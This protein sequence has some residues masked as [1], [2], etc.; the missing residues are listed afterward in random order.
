[1]TAPAY[2]P[3]Q[4]LTVNEAAAYLSV[5]RRQMYV[6]SAEAGAG[7]DGLPVVTVGRSRRF[8]VRDLDAFVERHMIR[9]GRAS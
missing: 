8:R 6:L 4:L 3:G 1:V 7:R 2:A 9:D 5:S